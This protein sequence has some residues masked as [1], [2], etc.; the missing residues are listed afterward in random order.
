MPRSFFARA[1]LPVAR[2]LLGCVVTAR[3]V[4]VRLT[5]VEA[6]AGTAD[7]A[8][9]AYRGPTPRSAV[10]FGPPGHLYVYFVYGMHWCANLVCDGDG[11]AGAVLLRA[12]AVVAGEPLAWSRRP[13]AT[14]HRDL[15]RGPARLAA[16]LGLSG[17]DSGADL[18]GPDAAIRVVAGPP[19]PE[20]AVRRGPRVG[21]VAAAERPWRFWLAGDP[22]VSGYRP[23]ARRA[24]PRPG[25][26]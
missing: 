13:A 26:G 15:A 9:H 11:G 2:D 23:A 24:R 22:T 14:R 17:V 4:A 12:G 16:V 1:P 25:A 19:V 7:P 3:G 20:S 18:C 21:V 8:S 6:Y 10:M 5:E